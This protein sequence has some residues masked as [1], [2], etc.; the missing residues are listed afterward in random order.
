MAHFINC[1]SCGKQYNKDIFDKCPFCGSLQIIP[2]KT[3][4]EI[5]NEHKHKEE[6]VKKQNEEILKEAVRKRYNVDGDISDEQYKQLIEIYK[7]EVGD[8]ALDEK[9]NEKEK[10]NHSKKIPTGII[11]GIIACLI[12][13]IIIFSVGGSSSTKAAHNIKTADQWVTYCDNEPNIHRCLNVFDKID[14]TTQIRIWD[15]LSY[16]VRHLYNFDDKA[17]IKKDSFGYLVVY[18][19]T[20]NK[21]SNAE[22]FYEEVSKHHMGL[23]AQW[24][25]TLVTEK[26]LE[27]LCD[28]YL[29]E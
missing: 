10:N 2:P 21:F 25:L 26:H 1:I 19:K 4:E 24:A 17:G 7:H 5:I 29:N 28:Q 6:L 11:I 15:D 23:D 3:A 12:T 8:I 13:I 27:E 14:H 22:A 9:K 16:M 18:I 20:R